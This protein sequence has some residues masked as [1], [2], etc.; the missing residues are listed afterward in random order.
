MAESIERQKAGEEAEEEA[1]DLQEAVTV[2][3][4]L[5]LQM[6]VWSEAACLAPGMAGVRRTVWRP[7]TQPAVDQGGQ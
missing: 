1:G 5:G 6:C 3:G 7:S 4:G 2:M